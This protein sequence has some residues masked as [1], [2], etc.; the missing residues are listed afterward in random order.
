[1]KRALVAAIPFLVFAAV[2]AL[3]AWDPLPIQQVRFLV[4]DTYQRIDPRP[5]D[6]NAPVRIVDIDNASLAR[7]GQWPWPRPMAECCRKANGTA[8]LEKQQRCY[9]VT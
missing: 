1:M 7:V 2:V 4:F 6:P 8:E 5:Y 3:R 9:I